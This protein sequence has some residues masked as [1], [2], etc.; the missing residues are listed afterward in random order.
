MM[1]SF[2]KIFDRDTWDEIL[3]LFQKTRLGLL[4]QP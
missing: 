1:N 4:S 2:K 3:N